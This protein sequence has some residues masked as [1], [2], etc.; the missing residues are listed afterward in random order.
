MKTRNIL[1]KLKAP[2]VVSS[3]RLLGCPFCGIHAIWRVK[4]DDGSAS[5]IE[6]A[7]CNARGPRVE[8]EGINSKHNAIILAEYEWNNRRQPNEKGHP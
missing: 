1:G 6:C 4:E 7:A 5:W 3:M 8:L 2:T